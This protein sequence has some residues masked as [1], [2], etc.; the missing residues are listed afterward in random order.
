M[1]LVQ[2]KDGL[3]LVIMA[4]WEGIFNATDL[5][6]HS[7]SRTGCQSFRLRASIISE[8]KRLQALLKAYEKGNCRKNRAALKIDRYI[9]KILRQN[10]S[11]V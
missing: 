11:M 10:P 2:N 1:L 9:D 8:C 7:S 5:F 6:P 4:A 3:R